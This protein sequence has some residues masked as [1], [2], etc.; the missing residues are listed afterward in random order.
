[1]DLNWNDT[2]V[3][4]RSTL[5]QTVC[6]PLH[7]LQLCVDWPA[8]VPRPIGR[9]KVLFMADIKMDML[10]YHHETFGLPISYKML[11]CTQKNAVSHIFIG[12]GL[13]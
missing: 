7:P 3:G 10:L 4:N 13:V 9:V 6:M 2:D 8:L 1:M 11:L 5:R 12:I